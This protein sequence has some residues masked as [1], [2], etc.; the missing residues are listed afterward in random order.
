MPFYQK[1][2]TNKVI[3]QFQNLTNN[4]LF[5]FQDGMTAP[6][7]FAVSNVAVNS[8]VVT[9]NGIVG[10][11]G[12][13][14]DYFTGV[15]PLPVTGAIAGVKGLSTSNGNVNIDPTV[16]T[17]ANINASTGIGTL[18]WLA[19]GNINS[20]VGNVGNVSNQIDGG[21]ITVQ[22]YIYPDVLQAGASI[23]VG[24]KYSPD[25]NDSS[26]SFFVD[27]Y[28]PNS[29][30]NANVV[31]QGAS[32]NVDSAYSDLVSKSGSSTAATI[33]GNVQT[34]RG[35]EYNFDVA[36]FFR[37]YVSDFTNNANSSST[38]VGSIFA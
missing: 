10:G 20:N 3:L 25:N 36:K 33:L 11:G 4:F 22:S 19:T 14:H 13:G 8:N 26:R 16:L 34:V 7:T 28:F 1:Q 29:P 21:T 18:S 27:V 24:Q 5:G 9:A 17:H 38:I 31:L 6:F 30:A 23:E 12:G 15:A 2:S 35:V 32:I 37:L